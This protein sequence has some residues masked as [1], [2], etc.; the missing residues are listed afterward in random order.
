MASDDVMS[1][2]FIDVTGTLYHVALHQNGN[3]I[4]IWS[5]EMC[6]IFVE[7]INV[8]FM[9]LLTVILCDCI[10]NILTQEEVSIVGL[11]ITE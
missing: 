7:Q 8:I 11:Y 9:R 6:F 1:R 10:I 5:V 2:S 4:F 3:A